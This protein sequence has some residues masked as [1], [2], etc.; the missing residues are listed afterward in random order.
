MLHPTFV[1]VKNL[2]A[3]Q[4]FKFPLKQPPLRFISFPI[5]HE[6]FFS[7]MP[8]K[9]NASNAQ[10]SVPLNVQ[11]CFHCAEVTGFQTIQ[12]RATDTEETL[13]VVEDGS[14][15]LAVGE[16]HAPVNWRAVGQADEGGE[17]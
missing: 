3:N 8:S 2:P 6:F 12:V 11:P 7:V 4:C 10:T 1:Q 5:F 14:Q 16:Q 15:C 13:A 17:F 9:R